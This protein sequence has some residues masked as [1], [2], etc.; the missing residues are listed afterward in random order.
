[1]QL[2]QAAPAARQVLVEGLVVRE[3]AALSQ[4]VADAT[5]PLMEA[6]ID[7]LASTELVTRLS[8]L[9]GLS[10]EPTLIF[11]HPSIRQIANHLQ[12]ALSV[13]QSVA[14]IEAASLQLV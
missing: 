9:S 1:M 8:A 3:I 11:T 12:N 4:C 10:L 5:T 6:G 14:H 13:S 7:S 2:A